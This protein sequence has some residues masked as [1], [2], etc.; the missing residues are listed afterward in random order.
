MVWKVSRELADESSFKSY[1]K[2]H[3]DEVASC[4]MNLSRLVK[5]LNGGMSLQS[6]AGFGFFRSEGGDVYRIAQS[7]KR[8]KKETRLYLLI[9]IGGDTI[10]ILR[11]GGKESQAADLKWCHDLAKKR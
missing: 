11:I 6:A 10:D 8:G 5:A 4:F 1:S 2:R 9:R 7:G 3:R